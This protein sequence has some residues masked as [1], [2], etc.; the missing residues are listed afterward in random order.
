MKIK[1]WA[2]DLTVQESWVTS[3]SKLVARLWRVV[4]KIG[5]EE[6]NWRQASINNF[7]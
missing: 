2:F 4:F 6:R 7:Q 1:H 3:T 5:G